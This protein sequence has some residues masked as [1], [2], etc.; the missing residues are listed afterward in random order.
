MI[1]TIVQLKDLSQFINTIN[2]RPQLQVFLSTW[3]LRRP[4]HVRK[5]TRLLHQA[6][7]RSVSLI[8]IMWNNRK[9]SYYS[10]IYIGHVRVTTA[11]YAHRK[12][13]DD[14]SI[15]VN[16]NG[17]EHF[18]V[19]KEIFSVEGQNSFLQVCCLSNNRSFTCSS[20]KTQ[21]NFKGIQ[22]GAMGNDCIVPA[23]NFIE[24]CVRVDHPLTS[25]ITFIRF[26]NLCDSS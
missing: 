14:S 20:N 6:K 7:N 4:S 1:N 15:I 9:I 19:V 11:A 26:P 13:T 21:F 10:T 3:I 16:I 8:S 24:K 17:I 18:A 12:R 22:Q 25:S 2:I 23:S 5:E